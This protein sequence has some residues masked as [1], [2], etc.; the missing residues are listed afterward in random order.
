[1]DLQEIAE[2]VL[3]QAEPAPSPGGHRPVRVEH[4]TPSLQRLQARFAVSV[5]L[6]DTDVESVIRKTVLRKKP[7]QE[8]SHREVP[9]RQPGRIGPPSPEHPLR[10]HPRRRQVLRRR[11][12]AAAHPPAVLGEGAAQHRPLRHQ[13]PV[14]LPVADRLRGDATNRGGCRGHRGAGGLHLRPDFH[15]PPQ[16]RR[17]GARVRRDHPQAARWQQGR[18]SA[19]QPVRPDLPDRQ[20]APHTGCR[21][22][23]AGER[24]NAGGPARQRSEDATGQK[25]EQQVPKLLKQLV[26][27]GQLMAVE[28]EYRLQTRE[29]ALWTHDFNRRRTAAL[30]DDERI[31][32][33]RAELLR[34]GTKQALK[35]VSLQQ[36]TSRQPRKLVF[37]LSSSRPACQQRRGHPVD[38]GRMERRRK[39]GPE[40][41]PRRRCR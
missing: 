12:P 39:V 7:E 5:Q 1:M 24:R 20:I 9:G 37:E 31:N 30:N 40:R 23:R 38:A 17:A 6:S 2:H 35:P 27:A 22:R 13:G 32:S 10:R 15:R 4:A 3:H 21:R 18:R 14:A 41:R 28:T 33:K 8:S 25:L 34:D 29:G 26:D 11:L 16:L 36:G 19:F